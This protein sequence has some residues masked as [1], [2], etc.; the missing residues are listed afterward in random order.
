MFRL[1]YFLLAVLGI[2]AVISIGYRIQQKEWVK[3]TDVFLLIPLL[4]TYM[5]IRAPWSY[6]PGGWINDR[7]HL[8]I[9]LILAAWLNCRYGQIIPLCY[10]CLPHF[11]QLTP[12][13][14]GLH[15]I[16]PGLLQRLRKLSQLHT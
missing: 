7:I 10:R 3:Q 14:V 13:S 16:M 2:A 8:Y 12:T 15:T 5:F 9:L 4:F 11:V 1:S 6:G